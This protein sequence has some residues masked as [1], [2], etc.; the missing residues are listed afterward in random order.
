MRHFLRTDGPVGVGPTLGAVTY[1]ETG[2]TLHLDESNEVE[3]RVAD[4]IARGVGWVEVDEAG[5][6][7]PPT[8]DQDLS[9]PDERRHR[10]AEGE[11]EVTE[12]EPG[13]EAPT[14]VEPEAE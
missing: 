1:V 7:I 11:A 10:F 14:E 9:Q 13:S 6:A 5:A 2:E 8:E 12:A 3:A 4:D